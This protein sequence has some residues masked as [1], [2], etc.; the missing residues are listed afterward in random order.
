MDK[1]TKKQALKQ[2]VFNGCFTTYGVISPFIRRLLIK[3]LC[4][5]TIY[6]KKRKKL[7]SIAPT[8]FLRKDLKL[9]LN[10]AIIVPVIGNGFSFLEGVNV[11]GGR[12]NYLAKSRLGEMI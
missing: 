9:F 11:S 7:L 4:H 1:R 5:L 3:Q 10:N 12:Q 2:R 8:F 6:T